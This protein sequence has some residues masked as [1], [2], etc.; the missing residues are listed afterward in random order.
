[1]KPSDNKK[2]L[3]LDMQEHPENYSDEQIEAMMDDLDQIPD[4]DAE[5]EKFIASK[6]PK[7]HKWWFRAAAIFLLALSTF[8]TLIGVG[9]VPNPWNRGNQLIAENQQETRIAPHISTEAE[10]LLETNTEEQPARSVKTTAQQEKVQTT[11]AE[12]VD[13]EEFACAE[14]SPQFPGGDNALMDFIR[15]NMICPEEVEQSGIYGRVWITF[16][17]MDD[18][19]LTNFKPVKSNLKDSLGIQCK[20]SV[21]IKL[22]E[23]E[24]IRVC[25][26]MPD[27]IPG[28]INGTPVKMR[29]TLPIKF[30]ERNTPRK[31]TEKLSPNDIALIDMPLN[32][33]E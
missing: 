21:I 33:G 6:S 13:S 7:T 12:H 17:I 28:S 20:D 30:N 10:S 14:Q 2:Q 5:W 9:V 31:S 11:T 27:W 32:D 18:G 4:V 19:T 23:K 29:Y 1:M 16:V 26:L 8:A 15:K 24:A 22:C 25:R 3:F